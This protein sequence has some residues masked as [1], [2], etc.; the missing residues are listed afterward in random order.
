MDQQTH[1]FGIDFGGS[2]IKGAPVD[3][4]TGEFAA[5]RIRIE[6]PKKATPDRVA[7]VVA[8]LVD[9]AGLAPG[10]PVG[11]TVPGVVKRGVV[12][13]AANIDPSWVG[14]DADALFADRLQRPVAVVN[15]AD[16]AG[17]AESR[18]GAARGQAGLVVVKIGRAS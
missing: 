7:A 5:D 2:G 18:Y 13:T 6:T 3:L 12:H 17:L 1:P 14:T 9:R 10:V 4:G 8:R 11:L 16:A 15:D